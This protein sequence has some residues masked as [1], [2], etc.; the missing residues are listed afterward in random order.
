MIN[1]STDLKLLDIIKIFPKKYSS[2]KRE[3]DCPSI[4]RRQPFGKGSMLV[5]PI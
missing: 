2:I 5:F 3:K 4:K 1:K